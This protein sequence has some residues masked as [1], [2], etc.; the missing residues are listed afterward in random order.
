MNA[1]PQASSGSGRPTLIETV[2]ID[3]DLVQFRTRRRGWPS[4]CNVY[5]VRDDAGSILVDAGLGVDPD[6]GELLSAVVAV[7]GTWGQRQTDL[8]TI[9]LTHTHTD[10]AGGAI[11]LARATGARVLLPQLGWAQASDP[12]WQAHHILPGDVF[13]E[14]T[15][16]PGF[17][18]AEHLRTETMPE[19]FAVGSDVDCE[20]MNDGDEVT[21]GRFR[22]KAFHTPGHDVGHLAWIDLGCGLAFTGDLLVAQGTSLPWYPPNAGGVG[23]YL[24]SLDRLAQLPLA[25]VCPGHHVVHREAGAGRVLVEATIATVRERDRRILAE[26]LQG[27]A[28][29]GK[30]DDLVYNAAVRGVIPWASSVTMAHLRRLEEQ[31]V[32]Y[33]RSDGLYVTE[34]GAAERYLKSLEGGARRQAL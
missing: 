17:D 31:G 12:G 34:R 23:N 4:S 19:L 25:I 22:L 26:T 5:L 13:S 21:V 20:L 7:L 14:I 24:A 18:V 2:P 27:P 30:L 29:F 15:L 8:H 3:V 28:P 9:L 10:H 33:R 6:V 32:V 16:A 1:T 11:P